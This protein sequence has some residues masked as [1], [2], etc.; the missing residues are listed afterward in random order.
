MDK[1]L[2]TLA[3]DGQI[4][5]CVLETTETV[6]RAIA[7]HGLSPVAAAAFGRTVTACAFMASG[8]KNKTDKLFVTVK[9]DGVGGSITVAG[10]GNLFMRGSVQNPAAD[11]P[12]KPNGKLD[13]GGFV[14]KNGRLTVVKSMG[15]KEPYSGSSRIVSGEIAEDFTSYYALSE[16]QPTAMALG[17][18]IGKDGKCIGAGGVI[19]QALPGATEETL[20]KAEEL[21]KGFSDVSAKI[22]ELG[23]TGIAEKY[24]SQEKFTEYHPQYKCLCDREYVFSVVKS[25]GKKEISEILEKDGEIKVDCEFCKKTYKFTREDFGEE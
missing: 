3:Y 8:L 13:V 21:V 17:V 10:N 12:L 2:K 19:V 23:A 25:L 24:F 18:L 11:L 5:L 22:K 15:L 1:L 20:I 14:G 6:N 4:S 7:I 9:G 16:Q